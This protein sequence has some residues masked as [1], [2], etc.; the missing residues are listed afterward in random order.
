[1][2]QSAGFAR[3]SRS[4]PFGHRPHLL[5][6]TSCNHRC[7]QRDVRDVPACASLTETIVPFV[8]DPGSPCWVW[9]GNGHRRTHGSYTLDGYIFFVPPYA[10]VNTPRFLSFGVEIKTTPPIGTQRRPTCPLTFAYLTSQG[11]LCLAP[12]LVLSCV[13]KGWHAFPIWV[14][15]SSSPIFVL[16][17]SDCRPRH[18]FLFLTKLNNLPRFTAEVS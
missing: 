5:W 7:V 10:Y 4:L 12:S 6:S 13:Q 16:R 17:T 18:Q 11:L 1:M 8:R 9:T 3:Y 2:C 15:V 14:S